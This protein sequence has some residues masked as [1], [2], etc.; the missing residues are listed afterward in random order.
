DGHTHISPNAADAHYMKHIYENKKKNSQLVGIN[1]VS[2]SDFLHQNPYIVSYETESYG[3]KMVKNYSSSLEGLM[4][5]GIDISGPITYNYMS[6]EGETYDVV[7][8]AEDFLPME[9]YLNYEEEITGDDLHT[10]SENPDFVYYEIDEKKSL[11][12]LT[13][14]SCEYNEHYR[15]VVQAMFKEVADKNIKNVA[16]D[17]GN[18]PGGSSM[19]ADEF[20]HYLDVDQYRSWACEQRVGCFMINHKACD[21][22]NTKKGQGFAGNVY[23]MTSISSF[24]AAMDFA[25]LIQDNGLGQ[26][27]GEPC[28]NM[29]ASYGEIAYFSLPESGLYMQVSSKN[30]HRVDE[31]K[32]DL[33]I[34]PD[35]PCD[36]F[37]A[38]D[39]L[40]DILDGKE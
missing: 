29:P 5:L 22:K 35:Y 6:E 18:N 2:L 40:Y 25:M 31:S 17:L 34:L 3:I 24:S 4:Y 32:E 39:T 16:V 7:V 23:V 30:W 36:Y 21:I 37:N 8:K 11:A 9:E 27:V 33:P 14:T 28:G 26:V 20:I 13:L 15:D 38:M 12:I 10:E 1:G 19:V